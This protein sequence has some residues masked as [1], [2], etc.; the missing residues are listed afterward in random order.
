MNTRQYYYLTTIAEYENLTYAAEALNV[1]PSALSKF[2]TECGQV[3][4]ITLFQRHG[5]HLEPTEEGRYV[6][7]CAQKI[8]DQQNRML[9]TMKNVT[10]NNRKRIRLA[11]APNRGAMIYSKIYKPFSRC[12]P[13]ISLD[14]VELY[15]TEQPGAIA[16]GAVDL[17]LG[18][19]PFSTD[20]ADIPVAYEELMISLPAANPL[21]DGERIRLEDLRDTPFVLQGTKHSIRILA[22]Q[23]F[24]EAGFQPVVAFES[25]D[26]LLVDSMMHQAIGVGFVSKAHIFPCEELVYRPLDPP[27]RQT[28]HLRYSL[29]HELTESEYYLAGI[30]VEERLTDPRYQ[31]S[32]DPFVVQ[33]LENVH[34]PTGLVIDK[35]ITHKTTGTALQ[36]IREVNLDTKVLEYLIAI[37]EEESLSGAADRFLL[38]QPALSRHLRNV[39]TMVGIP[40]FSRD[41]NRLRPTSAGMIFVNNSRNILRIEAEMFKTLTGGKL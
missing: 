26:V 24:R 5:R 12:Y 36:R 41:H 34:T 28:L 18:A 8:L 15:A 6:V 4:D 3:F 23:L 16:R 31:P 1:T 21:A 27:V 39:E 25:N 7:E 10:G 33:M 35:K 13:D 32:D 40:L 17:A 19:G 11:T 38:A 30:L 14:L 29:G 22:D 2:L 9:L 20:T 37:V